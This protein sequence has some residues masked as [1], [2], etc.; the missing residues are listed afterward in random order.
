MLFSQLQAFF[1]ET[2]LEV[3]LSRSKTEKI[4]DVVK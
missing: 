2:I 4:L 3:S 1:S